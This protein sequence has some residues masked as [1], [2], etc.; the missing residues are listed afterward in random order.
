[1]RRLIELRRKD[2]RDLKLLAQYRAALDARWSTANL[3]PGALHADAS[4]LVVPVRSGDHLCCACSAADALAGECHRAWA[5]P[6]LVR[7]GWDV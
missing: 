5:A 4:G 1:M 2:K 6:W 7:A 3:G